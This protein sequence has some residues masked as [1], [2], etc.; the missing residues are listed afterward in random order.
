MSKVKKII[1]TVSAKLSRELRIQRARDD[2]YRALY[3]VPSQFSHLLPPVEHIFRRYGSKKEKDKKGLKKSNQKT[4]NNEITIDGV[5]YIR[6]EPTHLYIL[7][8]PTHLGVYGTA[9]TPEEPKP[10]PQEGDEYYCLDGL[11]DV[12]CGGVWVNNT[13]DA[14]LLATGSLFRTKQEAEKAKAERIAITTIKNYAK[15][16][17]GEFVPNWE[18]GTQ[19]KWGI[20]KLAGEHKSVWDAFNSFSKLGHFAEQEHAE[21]IIE[22]FQKELD[23]IFN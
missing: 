12:V 2:Y 18:D 3:G 11:G 10:W 21:E 1:I 16:K 23:V 15:E 17:W 19:K 13:L 4:M 14:N 22:K 9:I 5:V 8:E 20:L 7:K 6:K